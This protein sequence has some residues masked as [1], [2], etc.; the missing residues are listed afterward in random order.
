MLPGHSITPQL[1]S[2]ILIR[3]R[4]LILLPLAL[5][6][7]AA[8]WIAGRLPQVYRSET[9]IMVIPQ[10]VPDSYVRS[11]VTATV[12]DRLPTISEQILSRTRLERVITDFDLYPELRGRAAMEDVVARMRSDIGPVEIGPRQQSFRV[13]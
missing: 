5:G 9:L 4:W 1:I 12:E 13:T 11:T 7:G 3:R 2:S 6:L 8:P 10:R